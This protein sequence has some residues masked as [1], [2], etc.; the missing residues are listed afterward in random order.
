MAARAPAVPEKRNYSGSVEDTNG[1]APAA[2]QVAVAE[3][4]NDLTETA[5]DHKVHIDAI[6]NADFDFVEEFN[7]VYAGGDVELP[8]EVEDDDFVAVFD[9]EYDDGED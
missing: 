2:D 5:A 3:D 8:V 9:S 6:Y 7:T 4:L 1:L